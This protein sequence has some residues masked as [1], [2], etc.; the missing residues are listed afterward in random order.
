MKFI[1]L[2]ALLLTL[3]ASTAKAMVFKIATLAPD[4]SDWMVRMKKGAQEIAEK[5]D[6]R[7]KFKFYPGGVMGDDKAVLRKIKIG[8]LHGAAMPSGS[9]A[10]YYLDSQVYSLPLRFQSFDEIDHV[11]SEMD[12][13]LIDGFRQNGFTILG[14]SEGGLA[15]AMSKSPVAKVAD[16]QALKVWVPDSDAMGISAMNTYGIDPI[17]LGIGDVLTGLQTG[18]INTI[19]SSPIAAIALQWHNQVDY[20]TDMPLLYVYAVFALNNKS[21]NRLSESD[22]NIVRAVMSDTFKRIDRQNRKDNVAAYE[23]LKKRGITIVTPDPEYRDE[24]HEKAERSVQKMVEDGIISK[25]ILDQLN[26]LLKSYRLER[27]P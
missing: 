19:A 25:P 20:L 17:P 5:T 21:F 8:Q 4:G 23:A 12:Q 3:F 27:T 16:L 6:N 1:Q 13:T 2:A 24:W 26:Q 14:L 22:Q 7:V 10:P 11:R 9:L 15:Y 18:L